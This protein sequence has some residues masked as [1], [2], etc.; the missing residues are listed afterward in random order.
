MNFDKVLASD[1]VW[2]LQEI[3][4]LYQDIPHDQRGATHISMRDTEADS[5]PIEEH[6]VIKD[7]SSVLGKR[8]HIEAFDVQKQDMKKR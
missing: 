3:S 7:D 4:E 8:S 2:R 1:I 6:K 5:A